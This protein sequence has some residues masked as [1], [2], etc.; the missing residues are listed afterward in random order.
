MTMHRSAFTIARFLLLEAMRDRFTLLIIAGLMLAS[1]VAIFVGELAITES[2]GMQAAILAFTL[3]LFAVF[4]LS[5]FIISSMLRELNDKGFELIL[6]HPVNRATYY[7]GKFSGYAIIALLV[8]LCATACITVF[9][10]GNNLLFW[11]LSL[12]CELLIVASLSLLCLFTLNNITQAFTVVAGFYLLARSIQTIQLISGAP[13]LDQQSMSHQF[14]Q[15]VI[16][17]LAYIIPDLQRFTQTDWLLYGLSDSADIFTV[18]IQ[19][20]IYVILLST[21]GLFDLYRKEL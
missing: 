20:L 12:Y 3:R 14:M 1:L 13:I 2:A 7:L 8:T 21:A 19:T 17:L 4:T 5:L 6:S 10:P 16:G 9:I 11:A 15:A 18:V